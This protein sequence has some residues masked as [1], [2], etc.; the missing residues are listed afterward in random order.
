MLLK[1]DVV[2]RSSIPVASYKSMCVSF[3]FSHTPATSTHT[4]YWK[5]KKIFQEKA[6]HKCLRFTLIINVFL[7]P[8]SPTHPPNDI[9]HRP[10]SSCIK[11]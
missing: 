1:R 9:T 11:R 4:L 8:A 5:K 6:W 3:P 2:E 10:Q 7:P